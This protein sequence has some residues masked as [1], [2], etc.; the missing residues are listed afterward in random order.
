MRV[1]SPHGSVH[2][3]TNLLRRGALILSAGLFASATFTLPVQAAA[4]H[5]TSA[6]TQSLA[7]RQVRTGA[8]TWRLARV[9]SAPGHVPGRSLSLT[10]IAVVAPADAWVVGVT[11]NEGNPVRAVVGHWNGRAWSR[12]AVPPALTTRFRGQFFDV[13]GASS[14]RN[15]WAVTISGTYLRLTGTGWQS[16]RLPKRVM[17]HNVVESVEVLSPRD[18]WV[19]GTHYTGTISKL[20]FTPFAA[21]FNGRTWQAVHVRGVGGLDPVSA[22]SPDNMWGLIGAQVAGLG[23]RTEPRVVHWNGHAWR[24]MAL[25]P[26]LPG[27]ATLSGMLAE[28][29]RDIWLG[30]GV[31]NRKSGTSEV[32]LHWNGKFWANVR[33]PARPSENDEYL[34]SLVSDGSGGLWAIGE[35]IPGAWRFWHYTSGAWAPPVAAPSDWLYPELAAVPGTTSTW[36]IA[37][38]P[39]LIRGLILIHGALPR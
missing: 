22:L 36:A 27:H 29:R 16:G 19:F 3:V 28:S 18:V 2:S 13:I 20:D 31:P 26:R 35:A 24:P 25:Q 15:V 4:G 11:Q 21:R 37:G 30:G 10:G 38:S 34:F 1:P 14:S 17:A 9:F 33:P 7:A 32:A 39:G 6:A 23:L 5:Q 12:A 8:G